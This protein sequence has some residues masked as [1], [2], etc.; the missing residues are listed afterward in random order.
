ME[1][2]DAITHTDQSL[3]DSM[4]TST[5]KTTLKHVAAKIEWMHYLQKDGYVSYDQLVSMA[6]KIEVDEY[7]VRSMLLRDLPVVIVT[8]YQYEKLKYPQGKQWVLLLSFPDNLNALK[9][10]KYFEFLHQI[11]STRNKEM[12]KLRE[13]IGEL[14]ERVSE[15]KYNES[16]FSE[17]EEEYDEVIEQKA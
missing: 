15:E 14:M 5:K 3:E 12:T 16:D 4:D 11:S 6:L 17:D 13:Y 1:H 8:V 10:K 9:T 2:K 7:Y